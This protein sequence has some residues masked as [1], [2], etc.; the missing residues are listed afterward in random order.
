MCWPVLAA[1]LSEAQGLMGASMLKKDAVLKSM[2]AE[3]PGLAAT[4]PGLMKSVTNRVN[5]LAKSKHPP[6]GTDVAAAKSAVDE[7]TASWTKA[8]A[9]DTAGD[10]ETAVN[11]GRDAKAKFEAAAS[12]VKMTLPAAPAPK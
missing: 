9:A 4:V 8:Q 7:G 2:A 3:W 12:A 6:A 1:V 5:S 10:T 11:S